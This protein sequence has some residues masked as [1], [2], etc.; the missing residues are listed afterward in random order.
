MVFMA[1]LPPVGISVLRARTRKVRHSSS[2]LSEGVHS[3]TVNTAVEGPAV[4][5]VLAVVLVVAVVLAVVLA[6]VVAVAPSF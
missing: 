6:V 3:F 2:H 1:Y 4:A 5:V